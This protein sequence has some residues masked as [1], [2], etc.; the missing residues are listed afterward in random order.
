VVDVRFF[1]VPVV[2]G[3]EAEKR[4]SLDVSENL[5]LLVPTGCR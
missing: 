1:G 4:D 5:R 2:E 3:E